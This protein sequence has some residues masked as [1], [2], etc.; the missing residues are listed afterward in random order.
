LPF[1]AA[2]TIGAE[3]F[4]PFTVFRPII[5]IAIIYGAL[6]P[7]RKKFIGKC[8]STRDVDDRETEI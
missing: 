8:T 7:L 4:P 5:F 1:D 6:G 2:F 3:V